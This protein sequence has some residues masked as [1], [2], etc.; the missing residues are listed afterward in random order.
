MLDSFL[1]ELDP[2]ALRRMTTVEGG[3]T[4]RK[5]S[6]RFLL[7]VVLAARYLK[8]P[9]NMTMLMYEQ[10]AATLPLG[11]RSLVKSLFDSGSLKLPC[12]DSRLVL[13]VDVALMLHRRSGVSKTRSVQGRI[14]FKSHYSNTLCL[15]HCGGVGG[16]QP[17]NP[18]GLG[19][20]SPPGERGGLGWRQPPAGL[21]R[22]TAMVL[23]S[24]A[25]LY[26]SK[27]CDTRSQIAALKPGTTG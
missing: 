24:N 27:V 26:P 12:W 1:E 11:L 19:G 21:I 8:N 16:R 9:V 6:G 23:Q 7:S 25:P 4:N 18:G 15:P 2:P 20:G 22:S 10:L 3:G 13:L 5:H 17:T 14:G